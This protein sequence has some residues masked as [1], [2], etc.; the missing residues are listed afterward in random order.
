[1]SII[2]TVFAKMC[3][4][5]SLRMMNVQFASDKSETFNKFTFKVY[6]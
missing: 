3:G 6:I 5:R 2:K 4:V 1:M